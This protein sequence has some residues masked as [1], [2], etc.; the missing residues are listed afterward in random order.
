MSAIGAC[1]KEE[2]LL[3]LLEADCAASELDRMLSERV[4]GPFDPLPTDWQEQVR[5]AAK[6]RG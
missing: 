6:T 1:S 5:L 3:A 4:S 2:Y